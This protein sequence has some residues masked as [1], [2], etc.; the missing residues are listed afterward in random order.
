MRR[1]CRQRRWARWW[2][3]S[4]TRSA[5]WQV[6]M[7]RSTRRW[8]TASGEVE[9]EVELGVWR[10]ISDRR[11]PWRSR[12]R[13]GRRGLPRSPTSTQV[14]PRVMLSSKRMLARL[15][16]TMRASTARPPSLTQW[17]TSLIL[18]HWSNCVRS[19]QSTRHSSDRRPTSRPAAR[20]KW[21]G[22]RSLYDPLDMTTA[23]MQRRQSAFARS[24]PSLRQT[25]KR[26]ANCVFLSAR[27]T[28]TSLPSNARSTRCRHVQSCRSTSAALSNSTIRWLPSSP[29]RSSIS[30]FTTRW[31]T[32]VC[33]CRRKC[34]CS[35]QFTTT[36]SAPCPPRRTKIS[37]STRWSRLSPVS[38][39]IWTRLRGRRQT[40]RQNE[41]NSTTD[42][43]S[44]SMHNAT[45]TRL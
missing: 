17:R 8:W 11:S 21:P 42:I 6:H 40:K 12:L 20:M 39:R 36:L 22:F 27:R 34:L 4:R 32:R 31:T 29:R 7:P 35:I 30:R 33:I 43:F 15:L 19:L 13:Q 10:G 1:P 25:G 41:T 23:P 5:R 3:C 44:W 37:F 16:R 2:A 28:G 18:R 38:N 14:L 24:M 45:I 26:C 9:R